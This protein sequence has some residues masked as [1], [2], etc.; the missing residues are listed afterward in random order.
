[1]SAAK[2]SDRDS[3][4]Y[5]LFLGPEDRAPRK[6]CVT[7]S[8]RAPRWLLEK[9][10]AMARAEDL[11][12]SQFMRRGIRRALIEAGISIKADPDKRPCERTSLD[13]LGTLRTR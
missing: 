8:F 11:S 9:G 13:Y 12:F 4:K 10:H 2:S 5:F 3:R 7:E 1:L 6:R